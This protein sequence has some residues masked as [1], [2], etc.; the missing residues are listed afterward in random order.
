MQFVLLS[1]N[2]S[3]ILVVAFSACEN[4]LVVTVRLAGT[5]YGTFK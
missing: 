2:V 1:A 5:Q 3:V 4:L